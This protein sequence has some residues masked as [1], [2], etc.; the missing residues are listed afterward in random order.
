M[1]LQTLLELVYYCNQDKQCKYYRTNRCVSVTEEGYVSVFDPTLKKV[2]KMKL[3]N[4]AYRVGYKKDI[5]E[6]YVVL[7]RNLDNFDCR[8]ENL[9]LVQKEVQQKV[10]DAFRSI[11][12]LKVLPHQQDQFAYR[13]Q[14]KEGLYSKEKVFYDAAPALALERQLKHRFLKVLTK[15]CVFD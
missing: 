13:V 2:S 1:L 3:C 12:S 7:T 9:A 4:L 10:K 11:Q 8:L 5:P 6:G 15:F 14:W